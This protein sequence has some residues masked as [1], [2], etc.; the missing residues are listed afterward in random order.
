LKWSASADGKSFVLQNYPVWA[1]YYT[2]VKDGVAIG[3]SGDHEGCFE[4]TRISP[5]MPKPVP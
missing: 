4:A 2:L 1:Q 5:T 3:H